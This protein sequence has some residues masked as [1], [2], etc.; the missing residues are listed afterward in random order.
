[1][2]GSQGQ[3]RPARM[4][5]A[6]ARRRIKPSDFEYLAKNTAFLTLEVGQCIAMSLPFGQHICSIAARFFNGATVKK[7]RAKKGVQGR[8]GQYFKKNYF[9]VVSLFYLCCKLESGEL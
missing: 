8:P 4:G 2:L 6:Q 9:I 1:M 7:K 3:T 5:N